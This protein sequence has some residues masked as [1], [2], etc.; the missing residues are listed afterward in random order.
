MLGLRDN[1][2]LAT[3]KLRARRLRLFI[4]LIVSGILFAV[5][6]LTSLLTRGTVHS[7]QSFLQ[8]GL[9]NRFLVATFE[10]GSYRLYEDP[11]FIARVD[12]LNTARLDAQEKEAKRLGI[13]FD[14]KTIPQAIDEIP[15]PDGKTI[16]HVNPETPVARQVIVQMTPD[17]ALRDITAMA[18]PYHPT[19]I[20]ESFLLGN[21]SPTSDN[22]FIPIL[23]GKE[24]ENKSG[25]YGGPGKIDAFSVFTQTLTAYDDTMLQPFVLEGSSLSSKPGDPIPI[26]MPTDAAEKLLGLQP[27]DAKATPNVRLARLADLRSKASKITFS[28]CY[29][30]L[31]AT[32]LKNVA[33]QQAEEIATGSRQ[34]GYQKPSLVYAASTSPCQATTIKSDTRTAEEKALATK[35]AAFDKT[36]GATDPVTRLIP[37]RVV[38]LVPQIG[39]LTEAT[40]PEAL[41]SSFFTSSLGQGWYISRQAA[42]ADPLFASILNDPYLSISGNRGH[43]IEFSDRPTQKNFIDEKV[44]DPSVDPVECSKKH[45]LTAQPYGNP[46]AT[47]YELKESFNTFLN[48]VLI[49]I[50]ALSAI[51]MI[52]TIGKIIADNRKETSVFRAVGAKR[53][54]IAQ[55]YLLYT[56]I[57]ATLSFLVALVIGLGV[58]IYAEAAYSPGLS[59]QAALAFNSS[60][61]HKTFH[62]ITF[63]AL[64]L[65]KILGFALVVSLVSSSVPIAHNLSRNPI[66]DMREE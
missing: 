15:S 2:V 17:N 44:C 11:D 18:K 23:N 38:G 24:I 3:T 50:A 36:F 40:G 22:N 65:L 41:I 25:S 46:L 13:P 54:E 60:D 48:Y 52:G 5:L 10:P 45:K 7:L 39:S 20:Y 26:I 12:K 55:I 62:L 1:F 49:G 51:V 34:A 59:V 30:N 31:A 16:K 66:K 57:L 63:N 47:L 6:I 27:L 29:R 8:T 19:G 61:L 33:E 64:D 14:R 43:F 42:L 58:A 28:A 35:Q 4:T 21:Y 37:F 9:L 53:H 56:G 32:N